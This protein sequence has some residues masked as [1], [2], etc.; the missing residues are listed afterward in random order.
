MKSLDEYYLYILIFQR[1]T[2]CMHLQS[3][4]Y[5]NVS[6]MI[7]FSPSPLSLFHTYTHT[8][9]KNTFRRIHTK[10]LIVNI[11]DKGSESESRGYIL[12]FWFL[13][14]WLNTF[15]N[16]CLL[17]LIRKNSVIFSFS[18]NISK[19]LKKFNLSLSHDS[20]L[21]VI[22]LVLPLQM[23]IMQFINACV[24]NTHKHHLSFWND[25]QLKSIYYL[26]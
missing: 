19:S 17:F 20:N 12:L 1:K 14:C 24:C 9:G 18:N 25:K 26:C 3:S 15:Y 23:K 13:I 8:H 10:L 22:Q 16:K 6:Y 21:I 11:S 4:L 5:N 7:P 2:L